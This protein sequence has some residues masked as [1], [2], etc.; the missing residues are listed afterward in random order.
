[1]RKKNAM[2]MKAVVQNSAGGVDT[3]HLA[4]IEKPIPQDGQLLVRVMAAGV[5][6]ADVVQREGHYPA[7]P[8]ASP[9]LGLEVSG[10]VAEVRGESRFKVGDAVFGLVHGGAYAEYVVLESALAIAKPDALGWAE[11]AT[12][13]EAWMTAWFNLVE[14]GHLVEGETALIHAGASGVGAAA[15]QLTRLLGVTAFA[16]AGSHAKLEFCQ[17][18]GAAQV[19]NWRELSGFSALVRQW[20]GVDMILDPVGASYLAENI[21]SLNPDG[22]LVVIGVMGGAQAE[23]NLAQVLMKRLMLQGSTLRPQPVERKAR[24]AQAL[25]QHVL[26]AIAEGMVKLT[27]DSVYPLDAVA[28]AHRHM[29]ADRNLGK[30][31]LQVSI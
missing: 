27:L 4:R 6:R 31:V 13:P 16:S 7:P 10:V 30:I 26:P 3:L 11:A 29:E 9:I 5:N 14:L 1:M 20:G 28:E 21:T 15:I 22:R 18:L 25:Q 19:F 23:L 17:Q 24:L 12:L 2:S 8:G